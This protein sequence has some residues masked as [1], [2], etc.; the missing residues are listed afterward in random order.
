MRFSVNLESRPMPSSHYIE[1]LR[2][3]V[4]HRL[5]LTPAVAV[6]FHD[7]G[8]RLL[9]VRSAESGA[10]GLPAGSIEPGESPLAAA[11]R[12]LKEE[13]GIHCEDLS[14]VAQLGGSEFRHT[15]PNGDDVEYS[16]FVFRG[17]GRGGSGPLPLDTA[18]V[19]E[20]AF[21]DREHA[22]PLTLPYPR[23]VLWPADDPHG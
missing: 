7:S 10:W 5:L 8:G 16:I 19:S 4:G 21:F 15:Y 12:E 6:V 1:S 23:P 20:A 14:L 9:L 13:T 22:P 2:A 18:E 17:R 11:Q 3:A